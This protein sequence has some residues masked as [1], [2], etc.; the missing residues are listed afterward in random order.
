M[1]NRALFSHTWLWLM[2]IS[3]GMGLGMSVEIKSVEPTADMYELQQAVC[4]VS[5]Q[6]DISLEEKRLLQIVPVLYVATTYYQQEFNDLLKETL[7]ASSD[8]DIICE[9]LQTVAYHLQNK[10]DYV[11]ISIQASYDRI[12]VALNAITQAL[13]LSFN[14]FFRSSSR[15]VLSLSIALEKLDE[16]QNSLAVILDAIMV[17]L[18]ASGSSLDGIE[19]TLALLNTEVASMITTADSIG[20]TC[21][22]TINTLESAES[23]VEVIAN[24]LIESSSK[25]EILLTYIAGDCTPLYNNGSSTI[26]LSQPGTYCLVEKLSLLSG[27]SPVIRITSPGVVLD[28]NGFEVYSEANAAGAIYVDSVSSSVVIKNGTVRSNG[29]T[30]AVGIFVSNSSDVIIER[31]VVKDWLGFASGAGIRISGSTKVVV[32]KAVISNTGY[33]LDSVTSQA[34]MVRNTLCDGNAVY[35]VHLSGSTNVTLR[36]VMA[37]NNVMGGIVVETT[38]NNIVI[39]DCVAGNNTGSGCTITGGSNVSVTRLASLGNTG[40]GLALNGTSVVAVAD[41]LSSA[42]TGAGFYL[43]NVVCG[44]MLTSSALQNGSHGFNLGYA[45]GTEN[46]DVTVSGCTAIKNG[47]IGFAIGDA[48]SR[49]VVQSCT[50]LNNVG[51]GIVDALGVDNRYY[52]NVSY[53]N[54]LASAP[55]DKEY[56]GVSNAPVTS[57]VDALYWP[58][59]VAGY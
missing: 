32:D 15:S 31:V 7:Y 50:A 30:G 54:D 5:H 2:R 37:E 28:L 27:V 8:R 3:V 49:V 42:C 59:N 51:I 23:I 16:L 21:I 40:N 24:E 12:V 6:D 20:T 47:A 35:G 1:N 25:T 44:S 19:S 11:S 52:S 41:C 34:V 33:G 22:T 55:A 29:A 48:P 4:L 38:S 26:V 9:G 57:L 56:L 53:R 43:Q 14:D 17:L 45:D 39:E 58:A 18:E 10:R 36:N 46:T 13:A